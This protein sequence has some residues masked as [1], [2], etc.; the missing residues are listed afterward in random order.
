MAGPSLEA[1]PLNWKLQG[2]RADDARDLGSEGAGTTCHLAVAGVIKPKKN[3]ALSFRVLWDQ[4]YLTH[5]VW[6]PMGRERAKCLT[7]PLDY[8]GHKPQ[9]LLWCIRSNE[10]KARA[11]A[12]SDPYLSSMPRPLPCLV[13]VRGVGVEPPCSSC[14]LTWSRKSAC[15]EL[16][17]PTPETCCRAPSFTQGQTNLAPNGSASGLGRTWWAWRCIRCPCCLTRGLM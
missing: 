4:I 2:S 16:R 13:A 14:S 9:E 5:S 3:L 1:P 8:E 11:R 7:H 15:C 6:F 17:N 10:N 12:R